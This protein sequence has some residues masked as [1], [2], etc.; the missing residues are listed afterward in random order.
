[1]NTSE[2]TDTMR[3]CLTR[4]VANAQR[5]NARVFVDLIPRA[6]IGLTLQTGL[7]EMYPDGNGNSEC[8]ALLRLRKIGLS[9]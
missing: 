2:S 7:R 1:M 5:P 8:R 3:G 9:N 6:L 4:T